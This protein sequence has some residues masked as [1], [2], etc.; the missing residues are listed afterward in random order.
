MVFVVL[1]VSFSTTEPAQSDRRII[2]LILTDLGLFSLEKR[3][4]QGD[5]VAAF[6]YLQGGY[7]KEGN[8]LFSRVYW[9]RTWGNDFK[10]KEGRFRLDI[11]KV[12]FYSKG[13]EALAQVARYVVD[14]LSLE[15]VK[16]WLDGVLSS[17]I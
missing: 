5:P 15:T 7:K 4:L 6:Q 1:C 8:T 11:N 13:G 17:L 12:F 14:A 9:D 3:R 10:L 16:V 2:R